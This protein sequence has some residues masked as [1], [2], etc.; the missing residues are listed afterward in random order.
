[1]ISMFDQFADRTSFLPTSGFTFPLALLRY[2]LHWLSLVSSFDDV[3]KDATVHT[4]VNL[5]SYA[6]LQDLSDDQVIALSDLVEDIIIHS[7]IFKVE[8]RWTEPQIALVEAYWAMVGASS[9]HRPGSGYSPRHTFWPALQALV[10]FLVH[11]YD[12]LY[13]YSNWF[14]DVPPFNTMC[15][16]LGF[17]LRHGVQTVYD[18][19]LE[20][21]CLDVFRDHSLHPS[22]V[23]VING[24]V[25]GLAAP[26]TS[27]NSQLHLDYLHQPENLVLACYILTT[28][29]WDNFSDK[30]DSTEMLR[31]GLCSNI[32]A[33]ASLRPLDPSWEQCRR[34]LRYLLQDDGG[35]FFIKQRK[36]TSHG[37][38]DLKPE[39][40]DQ[41]KSNISLA[42]G[43]LDDLFSDSMARRFLG[44]TYKYLPYPR[45]RERNV[46]QV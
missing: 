24:Y 1:M 12:A 35:E 27:I 4:L 9:S 11:Q 30:P 10:E 39:V 42:L 2:I 31:A 15:E 23:V 41:A 38:E 45:R 13:C 8:P 14:K 25:A 29:G 7:P 40:I 22:L 34:K 18:I 36:W 20:T 26:H 17:G 21:R 33:L 32:R 19:F 28:N 44:G 6:E 46:V 37:F 43:E 3:T 16:I 5:T